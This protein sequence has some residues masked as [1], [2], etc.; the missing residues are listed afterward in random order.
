M[1]AQDSFNQK[2]SQALIAL[3][4][5]AQLLLTLKGHG[6]CRTMFLDRVLGDVQRTNPEKDL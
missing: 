3:A 2:K 6:H 5:G 4:Q 1:V